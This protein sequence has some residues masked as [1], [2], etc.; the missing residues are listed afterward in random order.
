LKSEEEGKSV[1]AIV[2]MTNE[3]HEEGLVTKVNE[4]HQVS[5]FFIFF[6]LHLTYTTTSATTP[7]K[8]FKQELTVCKP[9]L[10]AILKQKNVQ[11]FD[12]DSCANSLSTG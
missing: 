6:I 11:L 7:S 12:M 9:V 3:I 8:L 2:K 4:L 10:L 1:S 5:Y